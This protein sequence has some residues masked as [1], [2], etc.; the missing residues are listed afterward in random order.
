MSIPFHKKLPQCR[1]PKL[2]PFSKTKFDVQ[3]IRLLSDNEREGHS[4]VFEVI[5]NGSHYA[6][7]VFKFYDVRVATVGMSEEEIRNISIKTIR[8]QTD[9]FYNE[10]RAYG[11]LIEYGV[12]GKVA[13]RCHGHMAI[14]AAREEE[15]A[16]RFEVHTWNRPED[17]S[18]LTMSKRQPFRAIVKDLIQNHPPLNEKLLGRMRKNLLKMRKLG[19]HPQDVRLR[20]YGGGLLLDFSIAIT[21]PHWVFEWEEPWWIRSMKNDE[22]QKLQVIMLESGVKTW[23]RAVRNREY[24]MKLRGSPDGREKRRTQGPS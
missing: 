3:F 1:G 9:P 19:V 18:R 23:L 2:S 12:N 10:C 21:K 13:V 17:D 14:L 22:M 4:H 20:N 8:F 7:K 5:I 6:L 24:C 11:R 16:Q 15:L